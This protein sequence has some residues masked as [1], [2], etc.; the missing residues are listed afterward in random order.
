MEHVRFRPGFEEETLR[1]L[2]AARARRA[3]RRAALSLFALTAA[4]ALVLWVPRAQAP[5]PGPAALP[6]TCAPTATGSPARAL[7]LSAQGEE[8]ADPQKTPI[9]GEGF[10]T[11]PFY[12]DGQ[13]RTMP[14]HGGG[15]AQV[16]PEQSP[17]EAGSADAYETVRDAL[18]AGET[19][20][21]EAVDVAD[22]IAHFA[23][24]GVDFSALNGAH[25]ELIPCAWNGQALLLWVELITEGPARGELRF[26]PGAVSAYRRVD[27][28][29]YRSAEIEEPLE[30]DGAFCALYEIAPSENWREAWR[31]GGL[32]IRL[33]T[34]GDSYRGTFALDCGAPS[35][36][37]AFAACVAQFGMLLKDSE[38]RGLSSY[39][40]VL[41]RLEALPGLRADPER[42]AFADLL[43]LMVI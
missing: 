28:G 32:E 16:L 37:A 36:D 41:A 22:M 7:A 19:P 20:R 2:R 34:E 40:G 35:E 33:K 1:R 43:R 25:A 4:A 6:P 26:D 24:G 12:G 23:Y 14:Y 17:S 38:Y 3:H 18:L 21:P 13:A 8:E 39:E 29:E 10:V 31:E 9:G 27:R 5:G 30:A 42:A 15:G 11:L